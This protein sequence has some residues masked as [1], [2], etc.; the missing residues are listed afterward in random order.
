MAHEAID[1]NKLKIRD[2]RVLQ[3]TQLDLV[4]L[5]KS[6][7]KLPALDLI[8]DELSQAVNEFGRA[9][10]VHLLERK[11]AIR[12]DTIAVNVLDPLLP[13][14]NSTSARRHILPNHQVQTEVL[15]V[16]PQALRHEEYRTSCE[17]PSYSAR[18][19]SLYQIFSQRRDTSKAA[20][21][22]T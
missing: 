16:L 11:E 4:L 7:R 8:L 21:R 19:I 22:R 6:R 5:C 20:Y 18:K 17:P 10:G 13:A 12:G 3:G 2:V 1:V 9:V 14:I 15:P